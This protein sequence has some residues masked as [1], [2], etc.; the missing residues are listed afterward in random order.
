MRLGGLW[1][2]RDFVRFWGAVTLAGLGDRIST[3]A[4]PLVAVI[5]LE[6]S[7]GE[8]GVLRAM[9]T[10]PTFLF[11]LVLGVWVDRTRRRG[12]LMGS[13]AA[14]VI[15]LAALAIAAISGALTLSLLF[16]VAFVLGTLEVLTI[17]SQQSLLP[18][19]VR[20]EHLV[21][22]NGKLQV[23]L[24]MTDVAGPSLAGVLVAV[25]TAPVAVA[26][27]AVA[28]VVAALGFATLHAAEPEPSRG[29]RNVVA[30]VV[31][32]LGALLGP[33]HLRALVAVAVAGVFVYSMYLALAVLFL[34]REVGL[35]A[36]AIGFA[37]GIGGAGGLL[38]SLLAAALADRLG[39]GRSFV[40]ATLVIPAGYFAVAFAAA[41]PTGAMVAVAVGN[42]AIAFGV[43][44]FNVNAPAL[45]QAYTPGRLLGRVNASWRF[46]VWGTLPFG[47]LAAGA[48]GEALGLRAAMT[49]I[50]AAG[51][52][53]LAIVVVSP[54]RALERIPVV[55]EA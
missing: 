1:R 54:L 43:A 22:A 52:L 18:A 12:L 23:S 51:L 53:M 8:M 10:A 32:G 4:L 41:L 9:L 24:S 50:A 13:S 33:L 49:A 16:L 46:I 7:A 26:A 2:E 27:S 35:G 30:E 34:A 21:E 25:V 29:R 38:G 28:H 31:E 5:A 47:S 11:S 55:A 40:A 14:R 36:T 20:R 15:L 39:L 44:I 48:L 17:V 6:A 45:R 3:L 37:L 42:A 19:L